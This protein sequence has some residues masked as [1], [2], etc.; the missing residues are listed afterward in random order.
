[1][2]PKKPD[3]DQISSGL[4]KTIHTSTKN[5]DLKSE[6]S[7]ENHDDSKFTENLI[8]FTSNKALH[9]FFPKQ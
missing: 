3:F 8:F 6:F 9:L 5:L 7:N 1:M 4:T 2:T